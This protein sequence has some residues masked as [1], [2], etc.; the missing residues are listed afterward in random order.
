M[1]LVVV[2]VVIVVA[3]ATY[4]TWL[5]SR[6]DR[7]AVRVDDAR[8]GLISQ[9][10]LRVEVAGELARRCE[11]TELG[12]AVERARAAQVGPAGGGPLD[13]DT[14]AAE[15]SLSRALRSPGVTATADRAPD[16]LHA[17]DVA[18][19]RVALARQLHNDAVRDVRALRARRIVRVL[20]LSGRRPLPTYFEIDDALPMRGDTG[21]RNDHAGADG[22][23]G[24][25]RRGST[26][27]DGPA[28]DGIA[29][30]SGRRDG[31][32]YGRDMS[33]FAP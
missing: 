14:E 8:T 1:T 33:R 30:D 9:L 6:L 21:G 31:S 26:T 5:A 12:E 25:G 4:L 32:T 7:L 11:L 20:R 3:I 24:D 10:A 2:T 18:A 16:T 23:D 17:V 29:R 22:R 19:A 15:N 28:R 27:R 13:S